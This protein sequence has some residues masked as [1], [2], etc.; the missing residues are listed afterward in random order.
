M[1]GA[2]W[3]SLARTSGPRVDIYET[4]ELQRKIALI[5][6]FKRQLSLRQGLNQP[7]AKFQQP[8]LTSLGGIFR[9]V[10][11]HICSVEQNQTAEQFRCFG[12]KLHRSPTILT[13]TLDSPVSVNDAFFPCHRH[14]A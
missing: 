10:W 14:S 9:G 2:R 3:S 11:V 5:R 1:A 8:D 13:S 12:G 7:L 4:G 6:R